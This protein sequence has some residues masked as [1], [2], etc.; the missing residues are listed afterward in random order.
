MHVTDSVSEEIS[1]PRKPRA[2]FKYA[3][4]VFAVMALAIAGCT[5]GSSSGSGSTATATSGS[6]T[7]STTT[8]AAK[9]N[10]VTVTWN[11]PRG[12]P[13]S[14]DPIQAFGSQNYP[15]IANMCEPL[16]SFT[17]SGSVEPGLAQSYSTPDDRTYIFDIRQNVKFW[18][19]TPLTAADAVFSLERS[20]Q[21][22]QSVWAGELAPIASVTAT[23]PD[24]LTVKLKAPDALFPEIMASGAG[25]V[26]SKAYV[27]AQGSRFGTPA[28]GVMCTGP[29]KLGGWTPGSSLTIVQNGDYW[30]KASAPKAG[31]IAFDFITNPSTL[32]NALRTGEVDGSY[33]LPFSL[34]HQLQ[35]SSGGK[36]YYGP[37]NTT[38]DLFILS[39]NPKTSALGNVKIRE[40]IML[41]L[42]HN[43][44]LNGIFQGAGVP[45]RAIAPPS[46]WSYARSLYQTAWDKLAT[47]VQ[48]IAAAKKLVAEAG[49]GPRTIT[50]AAPAE[51]VEFVEICEALQAAATQLGL[52]AKVVTVPQ[53]EYSAISVRRNASLRSSYSVNFAEVPFYLPDPLS[54]YMTA[55]SP[56]GAFNLM[57]YNDPAV[58]AALQQAASSGDPAARARLV[59]GAQ[60]QITRDLP[61]IPVIAP[62][63]T[64]YMNARIT[65]AALPIAEWYPWAVGLGSAS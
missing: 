34:L 65:G 62:Y 42:D 64:L 26:L 60:A 61:W 53:S 30:N 2:W 44:I 49:P 6:I 3:G 20:A 47:P 28:G 40:A 45:L 4:L 24:Q 55:A 12:G 50:C 63:Q 43:G 11:L 48:D 25:V 10:V 13:T 21:D 58:T 1:V 35:G 19:G 8:P 52:T 5:S 36:V 39:G 17:L 9:G 31:K 54:T 14:L 56:N 32:A 7:V 15:V 41:A 51:T 33:Y 29:F 27:T 16:L 59:A 57:G 22:P 18:D 23:G 37:P 46:E 38:G